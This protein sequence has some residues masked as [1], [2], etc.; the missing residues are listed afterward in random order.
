MVSRTLKTLAVALPLVIA[1][2]SALAETF[3][4]KLNGHGCAHG[5]MTCPT[6][7]LDPHILLEPDFVLQKPD[8]DYLFL[9]NV[10]RDTKVRYVLATVQVSGDLNPK[11]QTVVVDEFRVQKGDTFETVWSVAK[12]K[13]ERDY[14]YNEDWFS[15]N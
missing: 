14:L 5:G 1:V 6:D 9:S 15:H 8:G 7:R 13:A 12:E 10:P 11:Y 2:P 4:G 3:T